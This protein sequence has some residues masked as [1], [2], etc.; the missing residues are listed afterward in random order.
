LLG[1]MAWSGQGMQTGIGRGL[2]RFGYVLAS[3]LASALDSGKL[4]G[5]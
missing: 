1:V 4:G 2:A 5:A 3:F